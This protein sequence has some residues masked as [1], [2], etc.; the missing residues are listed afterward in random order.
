[1]TGIPSIT[2]FYAV[3]CYAN[4]VLKRAKFH[5]RTL[6]FEI[7]KGGRGGDKGA[8]TKKKG[9]GV[10]MEFSIRLS[11]FVDRLWL[12]IAKCYIYSS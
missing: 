11:I 9:H 10:N 7:Y 4:D 8:E 3:L 6:I 2:C 1:M 12:L 5:P